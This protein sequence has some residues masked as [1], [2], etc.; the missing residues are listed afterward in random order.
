MSRGASALAT[1]AS[2]RGA[3]AVGPES[4]RVT[5]VFHS[6]R[7][8]CCSGFLWL[9]NCGFSPNKIVICFLLGMLCHV[10]IQ[11]GNKGVLPTQT[12]FKMWG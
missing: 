12:A 11:I 1:A 5:V 9:L 2:G 7:Y 10:S 3:L 8:C 6:V 4:G